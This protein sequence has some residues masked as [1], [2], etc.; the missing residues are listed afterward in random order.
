MSDK[1]KLAKKEEAT[2]SSISTEEQATVDRLKRFAK[3]YGSSEWVSNRKK[4]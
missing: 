4:R 1:K 2:P 3:R